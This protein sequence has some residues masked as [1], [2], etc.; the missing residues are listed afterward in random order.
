MPGVR[1][2]NADFRLPAGAIKIAINEQGRHEVLVDAIVPELR[3]DLWP[4]WLME[5]VEAAVLAQDHGA[6]VAS[7]CAEDSEDPRITDLLILELRVSMRAVTAAAFAVDSFY[8]AVKVRSPE[9]PDHRRWRERRTSRESQ[10]FETLRYHLK[11][12]DPGASE[13]RSRIHQL[14]E[15]R[16]WA[17]HA[18]SEY[19]APV[20]RSDIDA[21]VDWHFMAFRAENAVAAVGMAVQML[22]VLVAI[23]DRGSEELRRMQPGARRSMNQVI[24]VYDSAG[25]G[26]LPPFGRAVSE[27]PE[28]EVGTARVDEVAGAPGGDDDDVVDA[29]DG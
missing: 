27:A 5:A 12:N 2:I 23:L 10:V 8:A 20:H 26:V 22:D 13:I 6:A 15:F 25:E 1:V 17:V 19:R 4:Y 9:H 18:A 28:Q 14:F 24:A 16:G 11:L 21:G 7:I 3:T 29:M